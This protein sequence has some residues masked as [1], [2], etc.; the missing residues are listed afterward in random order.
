[1]NDFINSLRILLGGKENWT[2]QESERTYRAANDTNVYN[3]DMKPYIY[4]EET[5]T[6]TDDNSGWAT[7]WQNM[8]GYGNVEQRQIKNPGQPVKTIIR[9][10]DTYNGEG[11]SIDSEGTIKIG[12][13]E[14]YT[15]E[16]VERNEFAKAN[17]EKYD[18]FVNV[19]RTLFGIP[20]SKK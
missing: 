9:V 8:G 17:Q 15:E 2:D 6:V 13:T 1:M 4:P 3:T 19:L 12:D 10:T 7:N 5:Q 18:A 16:E 14:K 20:K 11:D